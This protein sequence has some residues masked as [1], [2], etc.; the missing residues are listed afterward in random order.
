MN[1]VSEVRGMQ[2]QQLQHWLSSWVEAGGKRRK[3]LETHPWGGF[4]VS[5]KPATRSGGAPGGSISR[6][7]RD[8]LRCDSGLVRAVEDVCRAVWEK[9]GLVLAGAFLLPFVSAIG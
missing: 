8:P 3:Q 9:L 1:P 7:S 2:E 6:G 4:R 5:G